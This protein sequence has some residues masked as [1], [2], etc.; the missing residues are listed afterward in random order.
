MTTVIKQ[1]SLK[2]TP[3]ARENPPDT[4]TC[5][6]PGHSASI[7]HIQNF[8]R[9]VVDSLKN[10]KLDY[11]IILKLL[12]M[13]NKV[14][15][16]PFQNINS[17]MSMFFD[18]NKFNINNDMGY[19]IYSNPIHVCALLAFENIDTCK[20]VISTL[21]SELNII[22]CGYPIL[23]KNKTSLIFYSSLF[24]ADYYDLSLIKL[25]LNINF[26]NRE[27]HKSFFNNLKPYESDTSPST[28]IFT[29][30]ISI[31]YNDNMNKVLNNE[32][33]NQF[34]EKQHLALDSQ[35]T[36]LS[37]LDTNVH[38]TNSTYMFDSIID[39]SPGLLLQ[40]ETSRSPNY[41]HQDLK[42]SLKTTMKIL[43]KNESIP[44]EKCIP[45]FDEQSSD[46]QYDFNIKR[47][48]KNIFIKQ[49]NLYNPLYNLNSISCEQFMNFIQNP[50]LC[51]DYMYNNIYNQL[52]T[53]D[54]IIDHIHILRFVDMSVNPVQLALQYKIILNKFTQ[55]I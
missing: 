1:Q 3:L 24:G 31:K 17:Y 20:K 47:I 7:T 22:P 29:D 34:H 25:L 4:G 26:K 40:N 5:P 32:L 35:N 54:D 33:F 55:K 8:C 10:A 51:Y 13:F 48:C 44:L 45:S 23:F 19:L 30:I 52:G 9:N 53:Y 37:K 42:Q 14:C 2:L 12:L 15:T 50:D 39:N 38:S 49:L 46:N 6:L 27:S 36:Q 28:N 43:A 41:T 11:F 16:V 18:K 21:L